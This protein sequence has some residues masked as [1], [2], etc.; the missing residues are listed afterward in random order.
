[1]SSPRRTIFI[2]SP[3]PENTKTGF[4]RIVFCGYSCTR[5][6]CSSSQTQHQSML[7]ESLL[8]FF[9]PLVP[10]E[11]NHL[12]YGTKSIGLES[13]VLCSSLNLAVSTALLE[14]FSALNSHFRDSALRC[15]HWLRTPGAFA[16]GSRL[17]LS[18]VENTTRDSVWEVQAQG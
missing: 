13:R 4:R 6:G 17:S 14:M 5:V 3:L 16:P 10:C 9:F 11:A 1:M 2:R 15:S 12:D 7:H 18:C 8:L